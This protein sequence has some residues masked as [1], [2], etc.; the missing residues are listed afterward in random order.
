MQNENVL[1]RE[2]WQNQFNQQNN[3]KLNQCTQLEV[4]A[5]FYTKHS[6]L[7]T[8]SYQPSFSGTLGCRKLLKFTTFYYN[9]ITRVGCRQILGSGD[10]KSFGNTDLHQMIE[11]AV[12]V[13]WSKSFYKNIGVNDT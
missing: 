2:V 4:L 3:A 11:G 9:N 8:N 7:Y 13:Y 10:Q 1:A 12:S 5:N 6:L